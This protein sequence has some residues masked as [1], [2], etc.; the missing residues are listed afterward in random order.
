MNDNEY[1]T[2]EDRQYINPQIGLSESQTFIDNLRAAQ[3]AENAKI[4]SDTHALG[5]DVPSRMGGLGGSESTFIERYQTP[6][7]NK[8]IS[9]LKSVAQAQA[10]NEQL[11]NLLAQEKERYNQ[12]YRAY[13]ARQRR[14]QAA[15]NAASPNTANNISTWD[16]DIVTEETPEY[17]AVGTVTSNAPG[18]T[19][20]WSG[21]TDEFGNPIMTVYDD[22]YFTGGTGSATI[23]RDYGASS[24]GTASSARTVTQPGGSDR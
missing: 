6:K 1:T 10:M 21:K 8:M 22:P 20:L 11:S 15:Q 7:T 4:A 14:K 13:K 24:R 3:E 17:K 9:D 19:T 5:T 18:T 12:A 2:V 16:G 23:I